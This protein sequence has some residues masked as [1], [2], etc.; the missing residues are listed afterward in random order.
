MKNE[1]E[2][3][4]KIVSGGEFYNTHVYTMNGEEIEGVIDIQ[5]DMDVNGR[6]NRP[7]VT[8]KLIPGELDLTVLLDTIEQLQS[9]ELPVKDQD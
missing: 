3:F 5:V 4:V 1:K 2:N 9:V 8:L 7:I 6:N